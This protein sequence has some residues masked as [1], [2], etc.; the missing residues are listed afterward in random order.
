MRSK[1]WKAGHNQVNFNINTGNLNGKTQI[2]TFFNSD[3]V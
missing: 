2:D 3:N 1:E